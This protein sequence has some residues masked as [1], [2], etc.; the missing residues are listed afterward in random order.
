MGVHFAK[1]RP[2][3]PIL[4]ASL[5]LSPEWEVLECCAGCLPQSPRPCQSACLK[6]LLDSKTNFSR[7][8]FDVP[9]NEVMMSCGCGATMS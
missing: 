1:N 7:N 9:L 8:L 3:V 2:C 5:F 6:P 4:A